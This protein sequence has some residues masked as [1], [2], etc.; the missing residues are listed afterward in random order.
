MDDIGIVK[1]V[2]LPSLVV[3]NDHRGVSDRTVDV[4]NIQLRKGLQDTHHAFGCM[5][6]QTRLCGAVTTTFSVITLRDRSRGGSIRFIP[7]L[8]GG[9]E[10]CGH[11]GMETS[12]ETRD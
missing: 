5:A 8:T 3:C 10:F 2:F 11:A 1:E 7:F 9:L 4:I 6:I 12:R